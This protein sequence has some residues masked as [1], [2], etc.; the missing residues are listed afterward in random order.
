M[1]YCTASDIGK[2]LDSSVLIYL[3]DDENSGSMNASAVE[4]AIAKAGGEID[5]FTCGRYPVPWT[6]VP[7]LIRSL[8]SDMAIFHL[9]SRRGFR[10]N[11]ADRAVEDKYHN[12]LALLL[13]ISKGDA[14]VP[15]VLG[16]G[17]S[18]SESSARIAVAAR[19]RVYTSVLLGK[20]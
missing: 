10:D 19:D 2:C 13:R 12:A 7:A 11:T 4:E 15:A 5:A 17:E 3:T 18:A 1:A 6:P 20:Y 14:S 8:C 9:Y 16:T